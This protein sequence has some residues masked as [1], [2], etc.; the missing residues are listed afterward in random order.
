MLAHLP[1]DLKVYGTIVEKSEL[2]FVVSVL[3]SAEVIFC[4][5]IKLQILLL[6]KGRL[7]YI[8]KSKEPLKFFENKIIFGPI[9]LFCVGSDWK[10]I[11]VNKNDLVVAKC[12][13]PYKCW[14]KD[15]EPDNECCC[16]LRIR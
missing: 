13:T 3:F 14:K 6:Q 8:K 4:R 5:I 7:W 10:D 2:P 12:V 16:C 9:Y 1:L 15:Y 11:K